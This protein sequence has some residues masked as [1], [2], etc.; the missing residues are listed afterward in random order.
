MLASSRQHRGLLWKRGR[1]NFKF[2][3]DKLKQVVGK[4]VLYVCF[5]KCGVLPLFG[6]LLRDRARADPFNLATAGP[7]MTS[8][9][10][11]ASPVDWAS[12]S[13]GFIFHMYVGRPKGL[14]ESNSITTWWNLQLTGPSTI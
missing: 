4:S 13:R 9:C 2:N 10:S 8:L 3:G 1:R 14:V 12:V 6:V 7:C 5:V 11:S